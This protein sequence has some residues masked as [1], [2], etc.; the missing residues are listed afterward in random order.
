MLSSKSLSY[1]ELEE[2]IDTS[3]V[4]THESFNIFQARDP[5]ADRETEQGPPTTMYI[6]YIEY[7]QVFALLCLPIAS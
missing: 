5:L 1:R 2:K 3:L 7:F 6:Y 4:S